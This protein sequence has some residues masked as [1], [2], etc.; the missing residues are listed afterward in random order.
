MVGAAGE[1]E[2]G[3]AGSAKKPM[4]NP[5]GNMTA[6]QFI[7]GW[8]LNIEKKKKSEDNNAAARSGEESG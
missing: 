6:Q 8:Q 1:A 3:G 4:K 2:A 7:T 5:F